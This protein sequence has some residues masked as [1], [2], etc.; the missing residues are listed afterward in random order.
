MQSYKK[1]CAS[2]E[3]SE[4]LL[5]GF[6]FIKFLAIPLQYLTDHPSEHATLRRPSQGVP[7]PLLPWKNWHFPLF[8]R[9]KMLIFYVPCSPKLPLF[10]L[11]L[12]F[13]SPEINGLIPVPQNPWEGLIKTS[14]QHHDIDATLYKH[15]VPAVMYFVRSVSDML[16]KFLILWFIKNKENGMLSAIESVATAFPFYTAQRIKNSPCQNENSI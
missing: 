3:I 8:P 10:P 9:I 2:T 14:M 16:R 11:V 6:I 1:C 5:A 4:I 12:D 13:C 7:V 15:H